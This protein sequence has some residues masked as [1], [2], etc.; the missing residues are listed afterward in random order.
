MFL[1]LSFTEMISDALK[2]LAAHAFLVALHFFVNL[3]C[4]WIRSDTCPGTL[5]SFKCRAGGGGAGETVAA[6]T[7]C[8]YKSYATCVRRAPS[9]ALCRRQPQSGGPAVRGAASQTDPANV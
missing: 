9:R 2:I 6:Q 3:R 5:C 8:C 7:L 4:I 1:E